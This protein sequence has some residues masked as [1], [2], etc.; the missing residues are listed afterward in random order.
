MLLPAPLSPRIEHAQTMIDGGQLQRHLQRL[1]ADQRGKRK[2]GRP[3]ERHPHAL[4][5]RLDE[6]FRLQADVAQRLERRSGAAC[7]HSPRSAASSSR[8]AIACSAHGFDC[9]RNR[10]IS[11]DSAYSAASPS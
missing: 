6:R 1:E 2:L 7:S 9:S 4:A 3:H 10:C 8:S 5:A 11:G